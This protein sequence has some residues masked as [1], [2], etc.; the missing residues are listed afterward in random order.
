MRHTELRSSECFH[1]CSTLLSVENVVFCGCVGKREE[2]GVRYL[3]E[4][5]VGLVRIHLNSRKDKLEMSWSHY[6]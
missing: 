2:V 4:E 5:P 6:T 3:V 1:Y